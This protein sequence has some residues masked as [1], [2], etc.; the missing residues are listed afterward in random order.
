MAKKH[1]TIWKSYGMYDLKEMEQ[2]EQDAREFLEEE[3]SE[4]YPNGVDDSR[5][6]DEVYDRIDME[7]EDEES[8]LYK[9]LDGRILAIASMGLWNGRKSG[10]KILGN[11]LNEVLTSSIGCDEK[12]VYCDA[13]N[14]YAEGYHHDG[15][16]H[17]EFREIREDRNIENLLDKIYSGKEVTRREMNYYTRSL[18]PYI[19]SIYGI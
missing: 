4:D 16:N 6:T 15:R 2:A 13:Y 17:V 14:V 7:F 12:E 18:R 5:V 11:N 9:Q 19:K 1:T 8:N 3:Y 10:Y